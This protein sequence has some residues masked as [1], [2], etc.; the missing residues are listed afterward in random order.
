MY[1]PGFHQV[2]QGQMGNNAQHH[3]VFSDVFVSSVHGFLWKLHLWPWKIQ[4]SV[5]YIW[6]TL[7]SD[8]ILLVVIFTDVC[9]FLASDVIF[10]SGGCSGTRRLHLPFGLSVARTPA[11]T[12][13]ALTM[14]PLAPGSSGG[15]GSSLAGLT[16]GSGGLMT[17]VASPTMGRWRQRHRRTGAGRPGGRV[18][19]TVPH[20]TVRLQWNHSVFAP[21]PPKVM[22]VPLLVSSDTMCDVS[23]GPEWWSD[24]VSK[25]LARY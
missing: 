22:N 12:A 10:S 9:L 24:P 16:G 17:R 23:V 7:I 20:F 13:M 6:T 21:H 2:Q 4:N 14:T 19:P 25:S 5:V 8:T 11:V 3:E 1:P 18:S 15:L